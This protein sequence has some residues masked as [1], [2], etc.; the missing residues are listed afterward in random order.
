MSLPVSSCGRETP[1][2]EITAKLEEFAAKKGDFS[3]TWAI[4]DCDLSET[5]VTAVPE[6]AEIKTGMV[7]VNH[8]STTERSG[9]GHGGHILGD[10]FIITE[11]EPEGLSKL[12]HEV[13]V[14]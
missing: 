14:V 2:K 4:Q 8:P 13:I 5:S 11:G 3:R 1:K 10:S 9:K 7:F 6:Q 12:P